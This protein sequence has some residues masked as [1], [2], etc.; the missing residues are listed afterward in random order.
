[1][2]QLNATAQ[3]DPCVNCGGRIEYIRVTTTNGVMRRDPSG[4]DLK[5]L[6]VPADSVRCPEGTPGLVPLAERPMRCPKCRSLTWTHTAQA[7]L[8]RW[9]CA[10][11]GHHDIVMLGD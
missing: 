5:L 3:D 1:M 10:D 7:W 6:H 11:C 4:Y 9:D 2:S 8:N